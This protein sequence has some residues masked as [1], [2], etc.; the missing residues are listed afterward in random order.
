MASSNEKI[1][2]GIIGN[3]VDHS[4]S[5]AMHNAAYKALGIQAVFKRFPTESFLPAIE[6][7][8][9][10]KVAGLAVTAPYK[11]DAYHLCERV[12]A[13]ANS[14]EA[15]NT[16]L[17]SE[18][19]DGYN[20]DID[21][22]ALALKEAGHKIAGTKA[23]IIGG[24]GA[25]R[26]AMRALLR[27][28][29]QSLQVLVRDAG[30]AIQFLNPLFAKEKQTPQILPV[31]SPEANFAL[32]SADLIINTTP[33]GQQGQDMP[34]SAAILQKGQTVFDAI[35]KKG[36]SALIN[37]AKKAGCKTIPGERWLLKQALRQFHLLTQKSPPEAVMSRA[38]YENMGKLR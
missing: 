19:I 13:E 12:E 37:A 26:A 3:P 25:S 6:R 21:G 16:I 5:P 11:E 22:V 2:F 30:R 24:G 38:L 20:T 8:K 33:I 10:Q 14:I 9:A 17:L 7:A 23:V 15:V 31:K 34:F 32:E 35:Y 29:C 27:G 28:Q 18:H 36:G 4:L 1:V